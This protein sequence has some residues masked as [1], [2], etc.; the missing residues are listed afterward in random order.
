MRNTW[1]KWLA[2]ALLLFAVAGPATAIGPAYRSDLRKEQ[3]GRGLVA[4]HNGSGRVSVSWRYLESDPATAAF[5]LYRRTGRGREV[6]LNS[7]PI[8][9]STFFTDTQVDTSRAVSYTLRLAGEKQPC[10]TY[11]LTPA[12]AAR[13][14]LV[15]PMQP[16]AGDDEWRYTPNDATVGDLD[17][18]GEYEIVIKRETRGFDNAH[19]GLCGAGT[20]I[21]AYKLDG[22]FLW[23][24]DLGENIRQGAH[25]T[26]LS[27]YDFD[28]D[29]CAELAVKTAEGTIF[30]D[31]TVIGDTNG[32]G[33]TDYVDRDPESRTYGMIL[34]GPEFLSVIEGRTGRELA[35]A[36]FIPRGEPYAFGDNKGNRV[37]RFLAGAGWFDGER[38]SIL[39]CRGYYAKTVI[40]AWDYRDGALTLRWRFD[41]SAD[42]GRYRAYEGQGNHNLRIGDVDGDGCDEVT[43]GACLIDHDGTGGYNT[44]LGHGDAM[45]LTDIDID[46]PGLEIWQCHESSP[47]RAG[48]ELRDAATGEV[49]W[50]VPS[51]EDVGRALAADIDPD[52]RGVEVWTSSTE[53]IYTA[54]GRFITE[55]K[56]SVNMAIWWD[57]DLNRELLDNRFVPAEGSELTEVPWDMYVP[58]NAPAAR[59]N[60]PNRPEQPGAGA[61]PSGNRPPVQRPRVFGDRI[62]SITKWNGDGVDELPLPDQETA[63]VNNGTKANPCIYGDLFGDWREELVVR[64][65]DNREVRIYMTDIP[66]DYRFHTLMADPIYRMSVLTQN[67]AYNQPTQTGFYLGSD[68]GKFWPEIYRRNPDVNFNAKSGTGSDGRKNGMR[69]RRAASI[70]QVLRDRTL[71]EQSS[72]RLDARYDYE[73]VNWTIDGKPAGTGRYCEIT[74]EEYGYD[75]PIAVEIEATIHGATFRDSG[76]VTFSTAPRPRPAFD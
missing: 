23:R 6:K 24:V 3:L 45:H 66:T 9:A 5:D 4:I 51:I 18:D 26:Q 28:G 52:F 61:P 71:H 44:R 67:V 69:N 2:A 76:S 54:D 12:A 11:T 17:G 68:L 53:G 62:V 40:D 1:T 36:D 13:P 50:G 65:K 34:E 15:I 25:Y 56:P 32:D 38:P 47:L 70:V 75:R 35:R 39:M 37:D 63:L 10:A 73:S 14:Y 46:R 8:T 19:R 43:Y 59:D 49:L 60:R 48:S 27:L 20:L 7:E 30:G 41:T 33:R 58:A 74:A 21:E 31:G 42:G 55:R 16:V 57:G 64:S 22:T 29:G 72:I